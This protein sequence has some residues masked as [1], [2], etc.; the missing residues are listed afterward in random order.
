[1]GPQFFHISLGNTAR[2]CHTF[3]LMINHNVLI[4]LLIILLFFNNTIFSKEMVTMLDRNLCRRQFS[5][6]HKT[7]FVV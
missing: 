7:N 2:E 1:M 6:K 5:I 4:I 3:I